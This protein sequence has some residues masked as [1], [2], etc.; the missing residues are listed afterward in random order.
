MK[1]SEKD[2]LEQFFHNSLENYEENPSSNF[3][4]EMEGRIPPPPAVKFSFWKKNGVTILVILVIGLVFLLGFQK[5]EYTTSLEGINKTIELQDQTIDE[6]TKELS[7]VHHQIERKEPRGEEVVSD[8]VD[9]VKDVQ[10]VNRKVATIAEINGDKKKN[11]N[12]NAKRNAVIVKSGIESEFLEN[13]KIV[14]LSQPFLNPVKSQVEEIPMSDF[15]LELP[16][17]EKLKLEKREMILLES[18]LGNRKGIEFFGDFHKIYPTIQLD[19][20]FKV[21]DNKINNEANFGILYD[22]PMAKRWTLQFGVGFGSS[23]RS[24]SV[25]NDFE[26]PDSEFQ[27]TDNLV[28][29]SYE[30][31]LKTN[32]NGFIGFQSYVY[33]Y[34]ENDGADI[35]AGDSFSTEISSTKRQKYLMF[36]VFMKYYLKPKSRRFKWSIKAGII[37]RFAYFE[38]D[39][40]QIRFTNFSHPRLSFSH[41]NI[42]TISE[43]QKRNYKTE[44]VLATGMEYRFAENWTLIIDPTFK[45]STTLEGSVTPY[46]FGIYSGVRWNFE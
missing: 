43:N 21:S 42:I 41:T 32:Y 26:Y 7:E 1:H 27:I 33:N 12:I 23:T 29:T 9:L 30:F 44:L 17:E 38:N 4:S 15:L 34:R 11:N 31:Q 22:F 24:I 5:W 37:Q 18:N 28:R 46:T 39:V 16:K 20:P 8:Q 3:W 10:S 14:E 6:I 2:K 40:A 13:K 19:N 25:E 36:P 45:Q 35:Q